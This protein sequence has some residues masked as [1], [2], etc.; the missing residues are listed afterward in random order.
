MKYEDYTPEGNL[1]VLIYGSNGVGK[2]VSSTTAPGPVLI[3]NAEAG[4]LSIQD[5]L[6]SDKIKSVKMETFD[7]LRNLAIELKTQKHG[8]NTVVIDSLTEVQK[9]SMDEIM[10]TQKDKDVP[11]MR[12]WYVSIEEM[13]KVVRFFRDLPMNVVLICLSKDDKDEETGRIVRKPSLSG[14]L[15][16]EVC[17]YV[18]LVLYMFAKEEDG[19]DNRY[20][21]TTPTERLYAKDRSGK[22][23]KFEHP[24][25]SNIYAKVFGKGG[26]K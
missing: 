26:K 20:F 18:D 13:R 7:D 19:E 21:L 2:T 6:K 14:K 25:I 8:F 10:A 4:L 9:K 1:K 12:D 5:Q 22:L 17:G 23:D 24:D 11:A 3:A 15:P 16:E